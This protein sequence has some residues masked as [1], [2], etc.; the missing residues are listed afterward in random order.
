[1]SKEFNNPPKQGINLWAKIAFRLASTYHDFD[2]DSEACRKKWAIVLAKYRLDKAHNATSGN[3]RKHTCKWYD[4]MDEYYHDRAHV[5]C[6]SHASSTIVADTIATSE[7]LGD[8]DSKVPQ[9]KAT[10]RDTTR[11]NAPKAEEFLD[12]MADTGQAM[13]EHLKDNS[14]RQPCSGKVAMAMSKEMALH[15]AW[16]CSLAIDELLQLG[17][18]HDDMDFLQSWLYLV[19]CMGKSVKININRIKGHENRKAWAYPRPQNFLEDFL[20]ESFS[21]NMFKRCLRVSKATF[22][23]ICGKVAPHMEKRITIMRQSITLPTHVAIALLQFASGSH[24]EILGDLHG[25]AK[26]TACGIVLD[27]CKAIKQSGLWDVYMG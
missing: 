15:C 20:L 4:I 16:L 2:K 18:T 17:M 5:K 27:F 14:T 9:T 6:V 11:R 21:K 7:A 24:L 1:M 12:Q 26:S 13:L 23:Y 10:S 22:H 8:K 3:D 25:C 19:E